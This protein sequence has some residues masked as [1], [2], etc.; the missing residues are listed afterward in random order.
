MKTGGKSA[1]WRR[2]WSSR[3]S[4][5]TWNRAKKTRQ[6]KRKKK[7]PWYFPLGPTAVSARNS[8]ILSGRRI[9][10]Y[11]QSRAKQHRARG[12]MF[13]PCLHFISNSGK[14]HGEF[15]SNTHSHCIELP[16]QTFWP[17]CYDLLATDRST[18]HKI[19]LCNYQVVIEIWYWFSPFWNGNWTRVLRNLE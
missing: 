7:S 2:G 5:F 19:L 4:T 12:K 14:F 8:E 3:L 18:H 10:K 17:L 13:Q 1:H 16:M 9:K 11:M 6:R 15:W